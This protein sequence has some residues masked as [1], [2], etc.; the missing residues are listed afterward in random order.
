[1]RD[2]LATRE[3]DDVRD[4]DRHQRAVDRLARAEFLEQAKEALPARLVGRRVAVLSRVAAGGIEQDGLVGEPPVAIAR[5][6]DTLHRVLDVF[7]RQREV[8]P[9]ILQRRRLAR[10]GRPDQ[11][12]PGQLIEVTALALAAGALLEERER[13]LE[14]LAQQRDLLAGLGSGRVLGLGQRLRHLVVGALLLDAREDVDEA[15]QEDN[16][17]HHDEAHDLALERALVGDGDQRTDEPDDERQR[18]RADEG[19]EPLRREDAEN[20]LHC[21]FSCR[22]STTS[23]RRLAARPSGVAFEAT[24]SLSARPSAATSWR[25]FM[26]RRIWSRTVSARATES[27]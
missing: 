12:V 25:C 7:S 18:D 1:M 5:A 26:S 17:H 20:T 11:H 10:A 6:A 2:A 19:D 27:W 16:A 24:G 13:F 21:A 15:P 4:A 8:E 14:A 3:P 22:F 9:G 23:M